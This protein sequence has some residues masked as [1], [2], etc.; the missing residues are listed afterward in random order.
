LASALVALACSIAFGWS[1]AQGAVGLYPPALLHRLNPGASVTVDLSVDNPG[2]SAL[3]LRVYPEDWSFDP[4]GRTTFY[5]PLSLPESASGWLSFA[6]S[7]FGLPARSGERVTY[8]LDVPP[9]TPPGTYWGVLFVEAENP[10]TT[11]GQTLAT[12]RIRT[13]HTFY[14]EVP[15]VEL[16]G[17]IVGIFGQPPATPDGPYQLAIQYA[18][19]GTGLQ[20]LSG[21]I[22][23]RDAEGTSLITIPIEQIAALPQSV[24]GLSAEMYGP[25]PAG[26]YFA[27]V[28]I[29]YGDETTDVAGEYF[30][31]LDEP[32]EAPVP[33]F[34]PDVG[35]ASEEE[36]AP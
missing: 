21:S 16:G 12:F 35:D 33:R 11:P 27:L 25:L 23:L 15:P 17:E 5:P 36:A 1:A 28:V 13:G 14:V 29:N 24:R 9:G 22:D 2:D 34:A 26:D 7:E 6:P 30:F 19:T 4:Q 8:T 32:L 20:V 31:R 3:D 18:N 10:E